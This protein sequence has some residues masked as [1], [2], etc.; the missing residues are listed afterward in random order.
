MRR[1]SPS[2]TCLGL[3]VQFCATAGAAAAQTRNAKMGPRSRRKAIGRKRIISS[4]WRTEC[5]SHGRSTRWQA[6][7]K[8]KVRGDKGAG[9]A[10]TSRIE[11]ATNPVRNEDQRLLLLA[12]CDPG[13]SSPGASSSSL[14]RVNRD[15]DRNRRKRPRHARDVAGADCREQ[16]ERRQ[17]FLELVERRR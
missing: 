2:L 8:R 13:S 14:R 6:R 7:K 4:S 11:T 17:W 1:V 15:V 5:Y 10:A 9:Q 16:P 12:V 3:T